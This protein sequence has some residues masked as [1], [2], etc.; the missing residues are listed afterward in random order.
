[1]RLVRTAAAAIGGAAM[2]L[3]PGGCFVGEDK[4]PVETI[5]AGPEISPSHEVPGSGTPA[6]TAPVNAA[7]GCVNQAQVVEA[8][9][10]ADP[11]LPPPAE[12]KLSGPPVC[13]AGWA[14]AAIAA[15]GA[16][17]NR[18]VL[19]HTAGKWTVLTFG[20]APCSE[21]RVADA[22]AKVRAAAGC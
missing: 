18:V 15:P 8:L 16:D 20:S 3:A 11:D 12:A 5:P 7:A 17:E 19:R 1:M 21:P 6:P 13:E 10:F 22:P 9:I 14:Y 4:P 2:L